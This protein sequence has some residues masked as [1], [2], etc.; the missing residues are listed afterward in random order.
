MGCKSFRQIQSFFFLQASQTFNKSKTVSNVHSCLVQWFSTF[1]ARRP[2]DDLKHILAAHHILFELFF[3]LFIPC[4]L[5][6]INF[7]GHF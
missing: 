4:M 6:R 3:C 5:L 2:T 7:F 1:K